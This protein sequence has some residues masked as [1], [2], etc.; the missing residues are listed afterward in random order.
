M[1]VSSFTRRVPLIFSFSDKRVQVRYV[2]VEEPLWRAALAAFE[3]VVR[4]G[5]L[6]FSLGSSP[7]AGAAFEAV[8]EVLEAFLLGAGV[9]STPRPRSARQSSAAEAPSPGPPLPARRSSIDG[10]PPPP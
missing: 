4:E 5:V 8:A 9:Q 3:Q 6:A 7:G 10:I 1:S 2:A